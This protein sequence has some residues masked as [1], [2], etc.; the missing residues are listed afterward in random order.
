MIYDTDFDTYEP[1]MIN[2]NGEIF[3]ILNN[4][5]IMLYDPKSKAF[6]SEL[7][8]EEPNKI[9]SLGFGWIRS[10]NLW[11]G[12]SS[13]KWRTENFGLVLGPTPEKIDPT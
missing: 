10:F 8:P 6:E 11:V 4:D 1:I 13:K 5:S 2:D 12:S 7:K 9:V 3:M